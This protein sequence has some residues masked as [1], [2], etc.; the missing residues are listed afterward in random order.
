MTKAKRSGNGVQ[1]VGES[2][3]VQRLDGIARQ[4]QARSHFAKLLGAF[5][6]ESFDPVPLESKRC[7]KASN[8]S[9]NNDDR[10]GRGRVHLREFHPDL[11]SSFRSSSCDLCLL[12]H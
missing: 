3:L 8:A 9:P 4:N 11:L 6:H 1:H 2:E 12:F 7:G 5:K 10:H